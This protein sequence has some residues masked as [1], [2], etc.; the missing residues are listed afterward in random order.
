VRKRKRERE[1]EAKNWKS[2]RESVCDYLRKGNESK[3]QDV[4][5]NVRQKDWACV[6]IRE[7]QRYSER[8]RE[9]T[10]NRYSCRKKVFLVARDVGQS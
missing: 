9:R 8:E 4:V 1:R 5:N 10:R 2:V 7:R 6:Y 3:K